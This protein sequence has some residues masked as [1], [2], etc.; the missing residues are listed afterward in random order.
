MDA[1]GE[2]VVR[3]ERSLETDRHVAVNANSVRVVQ[4]GSGPVEWPDGAGGHRRAATPATPQDQASCE[5]L[6]GKWGR[7]GLGPREECNLPA[8]DAG[9]ECLSSSDC[10]GLCLAEMTRDEL[11]SIT[12]DKKVVRATGKCSAWR[13]VVGCVPEVVDGLVRV[14][15]ID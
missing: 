11:A 3:L 10:E 6:G 14:I 8:S 9:K 1:Q 15:C 7:I 12:R 4:L 2:L 5:A 13:I